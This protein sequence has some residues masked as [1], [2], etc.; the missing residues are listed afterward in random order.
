MFEPSSR[1]L[2]DATI[3]FQLEVK[4]HNMEYNENNVLLTRSMN[5]AILSEPNSFGEIKIDKMLQKNRIDP[6]DAAI[7]SHKVAMG[8]DLDTVDIND[9]VAAFLD[10]YD[11]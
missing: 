3:D 1:S 5:D 6:C 8:A 7:C 4:A 2:N 9:S 10:L 11:G